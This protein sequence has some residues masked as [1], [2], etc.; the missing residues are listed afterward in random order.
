[1]KKEFKRE[2]MEL[3]KPSINRLAKKA[4]IK[5]ISSKCYPH[6]RA[7]IE[8]RLNDVLQKSILIGSHRQTKVLLSR[9][10][11]DTL[12]LQGEYLAQS[13]DLKDEKMPI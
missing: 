5:T 11:Y 1:M 10:I 6:I 7:I 2:K 4:G 12:L 8:Q 9:D 13:E 3:V